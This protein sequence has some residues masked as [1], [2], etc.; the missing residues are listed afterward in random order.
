M[1]RI[2]VSG[3]LLSLKLCLFP[4]KNVFVV[5]DRNVAGFALKIAGDRPSMAIDVSESRKNI[6]SVIGICRWLT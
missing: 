4:Y 6:D 5:Y 3:G 2:K 1:S